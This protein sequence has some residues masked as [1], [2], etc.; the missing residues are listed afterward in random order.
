[1]TIHNIDVDI[2]GPRDLDDADLKAI[3]AVQLADLEDALTHGDPKGK[4]KLGTASPTMTAML[5]YRE[6]LESAETIIADNKLAQSIDRA[7]NEDA[8]LLSQV[9]AEE[10]LAQMDRRIALSLSEPQDDDD[11]GSVFSLGSFEDFLP[12]LDKEEMG[13][14]FLV[15]NQARAGAPGANPR[16]GLG[17]ATGSGTSG[18]PE[19]KDSTASLVRETICCSCM[20]TKYCVTAPCGDT[21]CHICIKQLFTNASADEEL[22]VHPLRFPY[23]RN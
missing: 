16:L 20:D 3:I 17:Y 9:M 4:R 22:F 19:T 21:Y 2:F 15:E 7:L 6:Y 18:A 10:Q 13:V 5:S 14:Q 23:S 11:S 8:E 1:M 12:D